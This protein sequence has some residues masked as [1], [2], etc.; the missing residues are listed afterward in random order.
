[1]ALNRDTSATG[2]QKHLTLVKT[3]ILTL[4]WGWAHQE[5]LCPLPSHFPTISL[6]HRHGPRAPCQWWVEEHSL[7]VRCHRLGSQGVRIMRLSLAHCSGAGADVTYAQC[8]SSCSIP[9]GRT[10]FETRQPVPPPRA[11]CLKDC[12]L[13]LMLCYHHL[14]ILNI[15]FFLVEM[16]GP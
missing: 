6:E 13:D 16:P 11:T 15:F 10:S 2:I 3:E 5:Y 7:D 12:T 4:T 9:T 14:E 1:M 8:H